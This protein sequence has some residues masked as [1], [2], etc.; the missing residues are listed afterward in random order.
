MTSTTKST[1]PRNGYGRLLLLLVLGGT[2]AC[3]DGAGSMQVVSQARAAAPGPEPATAPPGC[4][5]APSEAVIEDLRRYITPP[6][7]PPRAADLA[8]DLLVAYRTLGRCHDWHH[9]S[10]AKRLEVLWEHRSKQQT[11][12]MT[13]E[14]RRL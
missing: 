4:P 9:D 3:G 1:E 5:A 11:N 10:P 7:P 12:A 8:A 6:P 2:L 14:S 13:E